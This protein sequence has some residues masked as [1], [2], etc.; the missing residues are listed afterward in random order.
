MPRW[1]R[2]GDT[3]RC[4]IDFS[5]RRGYKER[6]MMVQAMRCMLSPRGLSRAEDARDIIVAPA[7]SPEATCGA[8]AGTA[9]G[10]AW[11]HADARNRCGAMRVAL[12]ARA[13]HRNRDHT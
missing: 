5:Q 1:H 11:G 13:M 12:S 6:T 7:G 10:A 9:P 3:Y 4:T 2:T 8:A